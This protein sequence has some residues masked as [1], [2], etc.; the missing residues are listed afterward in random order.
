MF[1][2]VKSICLLSKII[3]PNHPFHSLLIIFIPTSQR[4]FHSLNPQK[5]R[6]QDVQNL[7][8]AFPLL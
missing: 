3:T 8:L 4:R 1:I 7:L 5:Y 6:D 2:H